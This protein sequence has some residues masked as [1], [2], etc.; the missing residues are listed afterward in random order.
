M[1]I[2]NAKLHNSMQYCAS[3]DDFRACAESSNLWI[4]SYGWDSPY[5]KRWRHPRSSHA[6]LPAVN[7]SVCLTQSPCQ[8]RGSGDW[9]F[10]K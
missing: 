7:S 1:P 2:R 8:T 3:C 5:G 10:G 4:F 9:Q 6:A